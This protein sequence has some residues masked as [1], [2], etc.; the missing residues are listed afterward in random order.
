MWPANTRP[1]S[2]T[3]S[4]PRVIIST[5]YPLGGNYGGMMQAYAL[6][7]V[8]RG[9]GYDVRTIDSAI[10][11]SELRGAIRRIRFSLQSALGNASAERPLS[12]RELI[13][14]QELTRTF[15]RDH[16]RT[17][18][19]FGMSRRS[20]ARI[21][22]GTH[23]L[24]VGSDQV[25]RGGYAELSNQFL[26]YASKRPIRK[27]SYAASFGGDRLI[28]FGPLMRRRTRALAAQFDAISVREEAGIR[29]CR[30]EWGIDAEQHIDPTLLLDAS[31][32]LNLATERGI[33]EP[34]AGGIFVYVLDKTP[35]VDTLIEWI[36]RGRGLVPFDF[37]RT[38]TPGDAGHGANSP[39]RSVE[40]WV[41]GFAN[42]DFVVTDS[43]HGT[44]FAILFEKP[45]IVIGNRSRGLAR[46]DSLLGLLDLRSR[47]VDPSQPVPDLT[48]QPA[49]DWDKVRHVLTQE[50]LRSV[51]YL[52]AALTGP[53]R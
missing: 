44:V 46:F 12:K 6:Q 49:P 51:S 40:S 21:L 16:I 31:H 11:W 15:V 26:R 5:L 53:A 3:N 14:T 38:S 45:F 19:L 52:S 23:A 29:L 27:F 1:N 50:R 10:R 37:L 30:Q 33:D 18:D 28:R 20:R 43:F 8:I 13:A 7:A 2:K 32:Y 22:R 4:Q 36:S 17:V 24:V 25:W 47:L 39:L 34:I 48:D 42:A 41:Q 35:Q 9:M